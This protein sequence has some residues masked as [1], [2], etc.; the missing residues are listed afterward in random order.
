MLRKVTKYGL[1]G[2]AG[3]LSVASLQR[4]DWNVNSLPMVRLGRAAATTTMIAIDYKRLTHNTELNE[5]LTAWSDTHFKAANRILR[6]CTANG[7]VFI[8][9]GQHIASLEYL[10]P[11][12]YCQVLKVLHNRAPLSSL[13]D[14]KDVIKKDL[15]QST[16]QLFKEFDETPLG[17]SICSLMRRTCTV[18]ALI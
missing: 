17:E 6:L 16:E 10:V 13:A 4:N 8:K 15:G 5:D 11:Q 1:I 12:E 14:V 2:A 7:G 18:A 9:V 3:A